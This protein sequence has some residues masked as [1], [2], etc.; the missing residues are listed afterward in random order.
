MASSAS[1]LRAW[2]PTASLAL[3]NSR[4][5]RTKPVFQISPCQGLYDQELKEPSCDE[6]P[7]DVGRYKRS[8]Y[9]CHQDTV[10]RAIRGTSRTTRATVALSCGSCPPFVFTAGSIRTRISTQ[11]GSIDQR[12]A[13]TCGIA[14]TR[15]SVSCRSERPTKHQLRVASLRV[16]THNVTPRLGQ[17]RHQQ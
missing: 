17:R 4:R 13:L 3:R 16:S 15:F 5:A 6:S 1:R 2:L 7:I 10:P 14:A 12:F 8:C 11:L 9:I